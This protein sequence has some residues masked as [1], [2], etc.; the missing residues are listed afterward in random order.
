[1]IDVLPI[2]VLTDEDS[3]IFGRNAVCLGKLVRSG[4]AVCPGIAI[5]APNFKLKTLLEHYDYS[6]KEIIEQ[7]LTLVKKEISK[8]PLPETFEKEL[9]KSKKFL[10]ERKLFRS[11]KDLWIALLHF[12]IESIKQRIWNKGFYPGVTEELE[13]QVVSFVDK[14]T[15]AGE[16]NF[17]PI[18][19]D[20]MIRVLAGNVHP[21]DK[22]K[23]VETV[24]AGNKKLFLPYEYEWVVDKAVKIVGIKPYTPN[25]Y[26][27]TQSTLGVGKDVEEL[28]QKSVVKVFFDL[29]SGLTIEK[30]VDGVFIASEK[31]FDLNKSRESFENLAFRLV[32]SA[33]TFPNSPILFKLADESEGMGKVRGALRLIHQKSLFDPLVEAVLFARNKKD[34]KNV[35]IVIPFV[36]SQTELLQIKRELAVKKLMR[37]SFLEIWMEVCTPENIVN[38]ANY[39]TVGL[40]GVILNLN[41]LAAYFGGFDHTQEDLMF[42]NNEV[43][44]SSA[45]KNEVSGL[46]KFLEDGLKLLHKS[47]I[48]FIAYGSLSLYPQVLEFLVE[49]GVY[50]VV[51][52]KYEAHSIHDL[53][54]QVEK[55][56]ILTKSS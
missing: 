29:S 40:D 33:T 49:K 22:K 51:I 52:E 42:Y 16:A 46:L 21:A 9:G 8:I 23:I 17:D 54:H 18:Q 5:T 36:R 47:K 53:L 28:K 32:E 44:A 39:L 27:S 10:F 30:N 48:P 11:K 45:S 43:V 3:P 13:A 25:P 7:S 35:H 41:E 38:L 4:L 34:F 12:W 31:I 24:I 1:M 19:D 37:K 26:V 6:S 55:R 15:S 20:V 2:K 50:G 56:I 14:V